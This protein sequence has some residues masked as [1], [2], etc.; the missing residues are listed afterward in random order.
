MLPRLETKLTDHQSNPVNSAIDISLDARDPKL[1]NASRTYFISWP[2]PSMPEKVELRGS[3]LLRFH[4]GAAPTNGVTVEALAAV[5][6]D[7]LDGWQSGEFACDENKA[8]LE[9]F[10]AGLEA[11]KSR[12]AARV[13][14]GVEGKPVV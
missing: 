5:V 13:A 6:I 3:V 1:G 2:N 14:R 10:R 8:A 11:L 12:T 4:R 7:Q 9:H